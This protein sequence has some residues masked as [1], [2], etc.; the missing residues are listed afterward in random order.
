MFQLRFWGVRGSAPCSGDQ[1]KIFGGHTCCVSLQ[2]D[3]ELVVFDAGT[4]AYDLG[5]WAL[6]RSFSNI[7][8]LLTHFHFDHVI[9]LPFFG[10]LW[11]NSPRVDI[12]AGPSE[13]VAS[14]HRF[15]EEKM[16]PPFFPLCL[17]DQV[18]AVHNFYD[19]KAGGCFVLK[20]KGTLVETVAL[21]HPGGAT[22]FRLYHGGK[23]VCYI[24]DTEHE[25][26]KH[27][28]AILA[29]IE[30]AD[31]LIY[32]STYTEKELKLK[33][34][35]GHST[36]E[37]GVYLA[38]KAG[39]KKLVVFHHSPDHKDEIMLKIEQRVHSVFD[40]AIVAR[41]GMVIDL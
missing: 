19:V 4:G 39:V 17:K 3:D 10:P 26:G 37:E 25:I 16:A 7:S 2:L 13:G 41:Q 24:T 30:G 32:D 40:H 34:G 14:L 5:Q 9:G 27:D 11:G 38:Q 1:Y 35:W 12:Y 18:P 21:N 31:C 22:G 29:F 20:G 8:L 28:E 6:T 23:S 15:M 33:I 36:W